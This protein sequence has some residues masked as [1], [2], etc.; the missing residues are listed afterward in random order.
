MP[1]AQPDAVVVTR[2]APSPTG[3]LHVGN[4]RTALLSWLFARQTGGKLLLRLDDTDTVRSTQAYADSIRADLAWLG[5]DVDGEPVRQSDRTRLY[6][7]ALARLAAAG[8]AYPA[9]DTPEELETRRRLQRAAGKPPV[10]DRAALALTDASRAALEAQGH[11][12]HWRFRLDTGVHTGWNDLV[13]GPTA[14]DPASMSDPIVR[15]ADG[16]WLYLLTS[17]V[18]DIEM[19]VTHIVRGEDHVPNSAVQQQ[20]FTALGAEPPAMA[21]AALLTTSAGEL[22]KR[23]GSEGVDVLRE[24]GIEPIAVLAYLAHLGTSDPIEPVTSPE[25]LVASFAFDKLGRAAARYDP[26]ELAQLNH[27]TLRLLDYTDVADRLP[28]GIGED[29]WAAL[30]SNVRSVAEAADWT[31]VLGGEVHAPAP[32]DADFLAEAD[33]LLPPA[34]L[35]S[36]SWKVWTDALKSSTGR[37]G[38]GLYHP[39]RLALTGRETGPDMASLLPLIGRERARARLAAARA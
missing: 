2:F 12:P 6:D 1:S 15:R 23:I 31:G 22:S 29:A 13:R 26:E 14:L 25:P 39:L 19:G 20:M 38:R 28:A 21:H 33:A 35:D 30:R 10:Y 8:R 4:I 24:A 18:D 17:V 3:R 5:L 27:R 7:A 9:Y 34:P 32:E 16:T 37:K 11:R 36:A